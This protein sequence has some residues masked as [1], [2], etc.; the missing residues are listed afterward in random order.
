VVE[1][2]DPTHPLFGRR[3]VVLS[4]SRQPGRPALVTVAYGDDARLRIPL[5][6]TNRTDSPPPRSRAKITPASLR[7]LLTLVEEFTEPW[8]NN[9]QPSGGGSQKR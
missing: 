8:R 2:I 6:A 3:F 7:D 5:A 9:Q 4:V 1:V